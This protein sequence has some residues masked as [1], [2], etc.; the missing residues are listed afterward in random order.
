[1]LE[2]II[3]TTVTT[4]TAIT[5]TITIIIFGMLPVSALTGFIYVIS[6]NHHSIIFIQ[7]ISIVSTM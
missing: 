4:T 5:T 6:R 7:K 3:I 1:M 2:K